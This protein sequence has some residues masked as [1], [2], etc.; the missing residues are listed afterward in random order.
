MCVLQ[1]LLWMVTRVR[2]LTQQH[3]VAEVFLIAWAFLYLVEGA[4]RF[5]PPTIAPVLV[6]LG[7]DPSASVA[8][9][10]IMS[11]LATPCV[12]YLDA[13]TAV[14]HLQVAL[15]SNNVTLLEVTLLAIYTGQT[16]LYLD[17]PGKG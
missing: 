10:L 11:G 7:Y 16:S 13:S 8:C 5:G 2:A 9:C 12:P 15:V 3:P 6:S 4:S 17:R 1:C 14:S